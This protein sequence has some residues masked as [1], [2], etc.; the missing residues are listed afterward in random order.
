MD[1]ET[2][3]EQVGHS[4]AIGEVLILLVTAVL[5]VWLFHRLNISPILGY[6][7]GGA[8]IGPHALGLVQDI[9]TVRSLA[10]FGVVFLLFTIGLELSFKRL[11]VMRRL[12]FGLGS[13]QVLVT[14]VVIAVVAAVAGLPV[15]TAI[16]IGGA[17]AL[18]STALVLQVLIDRG[19]LPDRFGRAAFSVLLLQDLAVVPLLV[20][21]PLLARSG[22]GAL[23]LLQ[24]IGFA[25]VQAVIVVGVVVLAGRFV[26]RPL[27]DRIAATRNAE[28]F[29]AAILLIVLGIGFATSIAGL[30]MA[31][32][33]FLAGLLLAESPYRHQIE[34]DI[35][36]F[37][38]M[39]LGLFFLTVGALINA[40]VLIEH[41][42]LVMAILVGLIAGKA[43]IVALLA[44]LFGLQTI[45][46]ARTG[47]VL[48]NCGEFAFV[49]LAAALATGMIDGEVAALLA[50][51]AALSM[52]SPPILAALGRHL[53]RFEKKKPDAALDTLA[54]EA[55]E[56]DKH[57]VILGFGRFGQTVARLL[58]AAQVNWIALDL[59]S[60]QVL[61]AHRR[62]FPVYFGDGTR[63]SVLEAAGAAR[64][65]A[66]V[67]T[68]DN[69]GAA[70]RAVEAAHMVRPDLPVATRARD[71]R[72]AKRLQ[73]YGARIV[74]PE[75]VEASI[76]L[77]LQVLGETGNAPGNIDALL[78]EIRRQGGQIVEPPDDNHG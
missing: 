2:S 41:A 65:C 77:G 5:A 53:V 55:G 35:R 40:H 61:N 49:I 34:A 71:H 32:G 76:Q 45:D 60:G 75:I 12:V 24:A 39:L 58:D 11:W 18:S 69:P 26:L 4:G 33:A 21:V 78:D 25:A 54:R 63:R 29:V 15:E 17:L 22:G 6:L 47:L 14:S 67:V 62:G 46:A 20:L 42:A 36:P 43:A 50:L 44:R 52:I 16:V 66:V 1:I 3:V 13:A 59:D 48:A 38:G 72:Q 56:L 73:D 51:T 23:P 31:L 68:L 8:V 64:A 10:E 70:E 37:R 30:S 28:L 19:E 9:E 74:I 57:A 7:V 27:I